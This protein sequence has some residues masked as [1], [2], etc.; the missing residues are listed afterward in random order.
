MYA[1]L[2]HPLHS[3]LPG[4]YVLVRVTCG[5]LVPQRNTYAPLRCRTRQHHRTFIP[6]SVSRW[7]DLGDPVFDGVG[8]SGFKS[9][10]NAFLDVGPTLTS[11]LSPSAFPVISFILSVGIAGAGV[12]GLMT[13]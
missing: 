11:F 1:V 8:L 5:A 3:A 7:N 13:C 9:R 4:P 6:L 2:V 10:A 12:F